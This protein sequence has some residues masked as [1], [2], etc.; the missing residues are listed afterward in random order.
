VDAGHALPDGSHAEDTSGADGHDGADIA[1]RQVI[2]E[3]I[4]DWKNNDRNDGAEIIAKKL[5]EAGCKA[6]FAY[7]WAPVRAL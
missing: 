6:S 5:E 1:Q 4:T 2:S 3:I 7:R